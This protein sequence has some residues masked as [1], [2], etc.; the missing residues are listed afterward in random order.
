MEVKN[1][2]FQCLA[3]PPTEDAASSLSH[4]HASTINILLHGGIETV[5]SPKII[6]AIKICEGKLVSKLN[7]Y[8]AV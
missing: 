3:K 1:Y 8:N 2:L 5:M 4:Y 7:I 6:I